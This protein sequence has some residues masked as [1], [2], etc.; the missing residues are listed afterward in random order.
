MKL[1]IHFWV[2]AAC[3][4]GVVS[5]ST[6]PGGKNLPKASG[7]TG[8][9]FLVMDSIQWK[10]ELG[11]FMDSIL[12]QE[13]VGLPREE[14]I[15]R[16]TWI[17][18]RKLNYVLKQRRNL[19]YVMTMD[20]LGAGSSEV[21]SVFTPESLE[22]IKNDPSL[23]IQ[24]AKDIFAK[25]QEVVFL[26]G[27]TEQDLLAKLK[28]NARNLVEYFNKVERDRINQTLLSSQTVTGISDWMKA[29]MQASIIIPFGYKLVQNEEDFLWA[30][31]INP[32]DDKDIFISRSEYESEDQFTKENLIAFRDK[33]CRKYLFEDPD[34]PDTYL[35][36]ETGID[37][38]PV[39]TRQ[40][41]FNGRFA[42]EMRGL[43]RTNN[44]TMGG[45]FLGYALIDD[46]TGKFYYIEGF[47]Y[48]PSKPQREIMRELETILYSF[49]ISSELSASS[50]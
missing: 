11:Q 3:M 43:W 27:Q 25:G 32:R 50:R 14:G 30:R 29:N 1:K 13:M 5:C 2:A 40:I 45:P 42:V 37:Y 31:Q 8:D 26:F 23:Y 41:K 15:F 7:I 24:T 12:N 33:I 19:I 39:I 36:T 35:V 6:G 38:K 17:D 46:A 47:T 44:K 22:M 34:V 20:H 18:P 16:M 28:A 48:S 21:R 9:I 49:R 10:G 4:V